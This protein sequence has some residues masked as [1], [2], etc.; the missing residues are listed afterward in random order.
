MGSACSGI[1]VCLAAFCHLRLP[2]ATEVRWQPFDVRKRFV[3]LPVLTNS[4]PSNL[5]TQLVTG[6]ERTLCVF[7]SEQFAVL[8]PN[9]GEQ[10]ERSIFKSQSSFY[11][12]SS[13]SEGSTEPNE[14]TNLHCRPPLHEPTSNLLKSEQMTEREVRGICYAPYM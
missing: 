12:R 1:R 8:F 11:S 14:V 4:H 6:S 10:K 9:A 7:R 3:L 5:F 13:I 2:K